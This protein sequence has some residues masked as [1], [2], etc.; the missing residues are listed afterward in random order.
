MSSKE[1]IYRAQLG[2]A[3][4]QIMDLR[5]EFEEYKNSAAPYNIDDLTKCIESNTELASEN[6]RRL[7]TMV[8]QNKE[9]EALKAMNKTLHDSNEEFENQIGFLQAQVKAAAKAQR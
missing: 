9:I 3:L 4:V 5:A 8:D 6:E 2:E 7:Q 1:Q